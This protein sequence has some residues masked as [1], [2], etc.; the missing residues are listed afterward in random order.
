MRSDPE[1]DPYLQEVRPATKKS[2]RKTKE[3]M[4]QQSK[5]RQFIKGGTIENK[6]K[7]I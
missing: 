4:Q 1:D 3:Q 2:P 6:I 5:I 7:E